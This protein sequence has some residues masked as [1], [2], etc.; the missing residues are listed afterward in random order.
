VDLL[1][2]RP[3]LETAS[4]LSPALLNL[5]AKFGSDEFRL[6]AELVACITCFSSG[7][8]TSALSYAARVR[9]LY[10][11]DRHRGPKIYMNAP[12]MLAL[13]FESLALWFLGYPE[14]ACERGSPPC[15]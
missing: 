10:N 3:D 2:V 7:R 1:L 6:L 12:A 14:G 5:A 13:G 8:Y 9:V 15:R 4:E 11:S